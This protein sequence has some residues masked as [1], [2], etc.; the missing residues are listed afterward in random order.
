MLLKVTAVT[1]YFPPSKVIRVVIDGLTNSAIKVRWFPN[2]NVHLRHLLI[3]CLVQGVTT[4]SKGKLYTAD[5]PK[6]LAH[7]KGG[8]WMRWKITRSTVTKLKR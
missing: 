4:C 2:E 7:V 6:C 5:L 8:R 1:A 3:L